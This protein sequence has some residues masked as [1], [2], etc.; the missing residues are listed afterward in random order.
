[1]VATNSLPRRFL[2]RSRLPNLHVALGNSL[3]GCVI[4]AV[5]EKLVFR[6]MLKRYNSSLDRKPADKLDDIAVRPAASCAVQMNKQTA[7]TN[8]NQSLGSNQPTIVAAV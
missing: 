5:G 7:W 1:L 6:R 8:K 4:T 3:S 2:Q